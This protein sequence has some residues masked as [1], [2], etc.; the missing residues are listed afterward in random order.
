MYSF[1]IFCLL[2]F[3]PALAEA[4]QKGWRI[5]KSVD[6]MTDSITVK[7]SNTGTN[8]YEDSDDRI[9][10]TLT[11]RGRDGNTRTSLG[12]HI[13]TRSVVNPD[14]NQL[15]HIAMRFGRETK[16]IVFPNWKS[17]VTSLRKESSVEHTIKMEARLAEKRTKFIIHKLK[18]GVYAQLLI[19]AI[20]P[21]LVDIM[22]FR[23][24]IAGSRYQVRKFF[25][26]CEKK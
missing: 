7:L 13:I 26:Q 10:L 14:K 19:K 17:K 6:P 15:H 20:V 22:T 25:R 21:P 8:I 24:N 5:E 11:C 1:W 3:L 18:S 4:Q 9:V 2:A 12:L 23:L 16:N